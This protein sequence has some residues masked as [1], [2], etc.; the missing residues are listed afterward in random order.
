MKYRKYGEKIR[1]NTETHTVEL[2]VPLP[3][4]EMTNNRMADWK[5]VEKC[6]TDR[7][8]HIAALLLLTVI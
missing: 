6:D 4:K 2:W 8:A 1:V 5:A 7:D 3:A